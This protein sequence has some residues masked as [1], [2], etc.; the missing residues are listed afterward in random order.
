MFSSGRITSFDQLAVLCLMYPKMQFVLLAAEHTAD[1][2]WAYCK[3]APADHFLSSCSLAT[4][5][6]V[7]T[8]V[9]HYSVPSAERIIF[10]FWTL[11]HCWLTN[12]PIC[13]DPLSIIRPLIPPG[14]RFIKINK[15][16]W[17]NH[18][19]FAGILL[20]IRMFSK[21]ALLIVLSVIWEY[22]KRFPFIW[23]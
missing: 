20:K 14:A 19:L 9:Q 22:T 7:C 11:C 6:L 2:C 15:M 4:C 13:L 1:S 16:L 12:G 23:S 18:V 10:L 5:L 17:H 3:P 21:S 8:C